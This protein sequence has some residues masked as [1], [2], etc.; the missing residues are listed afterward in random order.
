M[1]SGQGQQGWYAM[2]SST[3]AGC[4]TM[5]HKMPTGRTPPGAKPVDRL[6]IDELLDSSWTAPGPA[7]RILK[8][9]VSFKTLRRPKCCRRGST[10]VVGD[11]A[12]RGV[13][14]DNRH[15]TPSP[16]VC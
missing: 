2:S 3:D 9:H 6:S 8:R 5:I 7:V 1:S 4:T 14:E 10:I 12:Q 13:W 16:T 15:F 11:S